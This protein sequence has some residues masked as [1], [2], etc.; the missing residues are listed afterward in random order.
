[1][2]LAVRPRQRGGSGP[3]FMGFRHGRCRLPS[4][5]CVLQRGVAYA[6]ARGWSSP[7]LLVPRSSLTAGECRERLS[8]CHPSVEQ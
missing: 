1:M 5:Q 3:W 4:S 2:L 6:Y 8:S 7:P